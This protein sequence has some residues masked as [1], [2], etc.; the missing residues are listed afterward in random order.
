MHH[1]LTD[2][3]EVGAQSLDW[4]KLAQNRSWWWPFVNTVMNVR[5]LS[6]SVAFPAMLVHCQLVHCQLVLPKSTT[7]YL[8]PAAH[9][10]TYLQRAACVS[11]TGR[12]TVF[13][14]AI[15]EESAIQ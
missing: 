4:I 6:I 12:A 13:T 8:R 7:V 1:Q 2:L 14:K 9:R 11:G 5:A 15:C 10:V 3:S